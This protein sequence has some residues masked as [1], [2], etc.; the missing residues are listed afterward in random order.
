MINLVCERAMARAQEAPTTVVSEALI[1][2][3]A[4]DL[5]LQA[6]RT[7]GGAVGR[8]VGVAGLV[9]SVLVGAAAAAWVFRDAVNRVLQQWR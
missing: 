1:D 9:L 2:T 4:D 6:P 7:G 8:L 5:D 3:A